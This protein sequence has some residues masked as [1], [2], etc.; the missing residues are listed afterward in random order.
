MSTS[1]DYGILNGV[2]T[3]APSPVTNKRTQ[4]WIA[5]HDGA[6]QRLP[7]Y[8]RSFISFAYGG[9]LIEDFGFITITKDNSLSRQLYAEFEDTTTESD[10]YDGQIYW[11]THFKANRLTL[12]LYTDGVTEKQLEEFK[13][14][15]KPGIIRELVLA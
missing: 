3:T 9:K 11:A 7:H 14:W 6:D 2:V 8:L 4:V 1:N 12:N 13:A 15:F 5:T 10:V